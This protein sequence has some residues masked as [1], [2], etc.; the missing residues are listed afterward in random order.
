MIICKEC[1]FIKEA[2]KDKC[3]Y[4]NERFNKKDGCSGFSRFV[5]I[6]KEVVRFLTSNPLWRNR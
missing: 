6:H 1:E 2:K 4:P 3:P 5:P